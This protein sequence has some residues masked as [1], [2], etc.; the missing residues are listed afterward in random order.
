MPMLPNIL[1]T[2]PPD[3]S[4]KDAAT[5]LPWERGARGDQFDH[6][7]NRALSVAAND[8][9]PVETGISEI[10]ETGVI[11]A[12]GYVYGSQYLPPV[13]VS[14]LPP[15][16][17]APLANPGQPNQVAKPPQAINQNSTDAGILNLL[18]NV[19]DENASPKSREAKSTKP[20]PSANQA[21]VTRNNPATITGPTVQPEI[22]RAN[23]SSQMVPAT[24]AGPA[25]ATEELRTATDIAAVS[26]TAGILS[27]STSVKNITAASAKTP[28]TDI[29]QSHLSVGAAQTIRKEIESESAAS[30]NLE[31]FANVSSTNPRTAGSTPVT[32]QAAPP[33]CE[34]DAGKISAKSAAN[35]TEQSSPAGSD[36]FSAQQANGSAQAPSA[37]DGTS[38]ALVME[39]MNTDGKQDKTADLAGK[40]L[41]GGIALVAH[42]SD[43]STGTAQTA[44]TATVP[45]LSS[46]S[47][48]GANVSASAGVESYSA[49]D[50]PLQTIERTHD[51]V[52]A[53]AMR[54]DN[55]GSNTLSVVIKP[56]S[57]T[58]LS[59]ELKQ[60]SDG[61]EVQAALQRGDYQHLN[62][63]WPDLQQ[64]LEQRGIRLAPLMDQATFSNN[65]SGQFKQQTNQP[66][67]VSAAPESGSTQTATVMQAVPRAKAATGW[68]TWA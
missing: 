31:T 39:A 50:L 19:G 65:G 62:Q 32:E 49:G 20:I 30:S 1:L 13:P 6:L 52:S 5:G 26:V 7:M 10:G 11:P 12:P 53:H 54:L 45:A 59:L 17:P 55:A 36:S 9:K 60:H 43:L 8:K 29:L 41:P 58:Q 56:G 28:V 63:N 48:S 42:G 27:A 16:S 61:V 34:V 3:L 37:G 46:N 15:T 67:E 33:I 4:Q 2:T 66:N 44:P 51:L 24:L 22:D 25:V 21:E 18:K 23:L 14:A 57:G 68:E 35:P 47:L 40:F 38:S 64:R